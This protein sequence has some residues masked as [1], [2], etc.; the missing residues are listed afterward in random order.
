ME[1]ENELKELINKYRDLFGKN[2][3]SSI[4]NINFVLVDN[5]LFSSV[6][7]KVKELNKV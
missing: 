7:K 5:N 3:E 4:N 1:F 2:V 6:V